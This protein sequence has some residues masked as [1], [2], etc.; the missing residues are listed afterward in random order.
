MT[1]PLLVSALV[2]AFALTAGC[3]MFSKK[4]ARPKESS[5]IASDVEATFRRRWMDKRVGELTAQGATAEAA[6]AQADAEFRE[7]Y[8]FDQRPKK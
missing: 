7:K 8:P 5:A 6:R 2:V 1:K 3:N 4:S